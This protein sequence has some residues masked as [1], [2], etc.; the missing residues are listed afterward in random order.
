MDR[1]TK[2]QLQE[3]TDID[4]AICMLNERKN[5]LT[6]PYSPLA[7]KINQAIATL[8]EIGEKQKHNE[9]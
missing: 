8:S 1:W 2:K 9:C 4:F 5:K 3:M 6:N 7:E